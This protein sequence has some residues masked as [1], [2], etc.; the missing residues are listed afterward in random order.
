MIW[1]FMLLV[2]AYLPLSAHFLRDGNWAVAVLLALLPLLS[3]TRTSI[4][5]KLLQAGLVSGALLVWFPTAYEIGQMRMATGQPW[6]RMALILSG[7][8][9]FSLAAAWFTGGMKKTTSLDMER[10]T[11]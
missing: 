4:V 11:T 3:L 6:L 10:Q 1:R 8:M 7:V 9:L 5:L 2:A